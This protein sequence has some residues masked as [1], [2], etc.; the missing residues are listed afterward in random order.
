MSVTQTVL[1]NVRDNPPYEKWYAECAAKFGAA[2]LAT[3]RRMLIRAVMFAGHSA[4]NRVSMCEA[5]YSAWVVDNY[6][7]D[8]R[9]A[10]CP[11]RWEDLLDSASRYIFGLDIDWF[12]RDKWELVND[13]ARNIKGL[14][15]V[16][17][18]FA[19]AL[20]GYNIA[21]L[22][23]H[24]LQMAGYSVDD[25]NYIYRI[26]SPKKRKDAIDTYRAYHDA[27]FPADARREQWA[28]FARDEP[29]FGASGHRCYFLSQGIAC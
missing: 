27:I 14:G 16:K 2:P 28:F 5:D 8:Y 3:K 29:T 7:P 21:C 19:L 18:S 11:K 13:L 15:A 12:S 22:D 20:V 10:F 23:T 17:A 1:A 24:A 26:T 9:P 25:A 4:N 6:R